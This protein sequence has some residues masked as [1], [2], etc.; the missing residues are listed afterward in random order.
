M[1]M[2]GKPNTG[3]IYII[4]MLNIVVFFSVINVTFNLPMNFVNLN[5]CAIVVLLLC[6]CPFL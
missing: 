2:T 4:L 6:I 3:L 1:M 5:V